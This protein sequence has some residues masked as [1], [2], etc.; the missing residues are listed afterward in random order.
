MNPVRSELLAAVERSPEAALAHDRAGWV[1]LF[2]EDGCVE[3]PVGSRPHVG[4]EQIER[5]YDTFIGPRDITFHRDLDVV[6]GTS[7]ARDLT[8]EVV[9]AS[10]LT[11]MIPAI[12]RYDLRPG[13]DGWRIVR[14]RAHWE[15][16][17]MMAQFLKSG[18]AS[19]PA[20]FQL[21]GA[22]LRNQRLAGTAGFMR[23]F[24]GA[25]AR[26]KRLVSEHVAQQGERCDKIVASGYTVAAST[27]APTGR[28]VLFADI[29]PR[30]R[31]IVSVERF[32]E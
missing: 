23:G 31:E 9:M 15:L 24:R 25:G 4:R 27:T 2:T 26:G 1:G 17:G 10:R 5:F 30:T 28:S 18:L 14:L 20:S 32:A 19:V 3:D 21:S 16:P 7:V 6:S 12:L 29:A 13:E 11:M 8:I 22:L